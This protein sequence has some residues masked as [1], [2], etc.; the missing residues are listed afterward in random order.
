MG[1]VAAVRL[2]G[3]TKFYGRRLGVQDVSFEVNPGEVV[4]FLGPNGSGKTTVLRML[5]GLLRPTPGRAEVFGSDVS[6]SGPDIRERV[7]YLPGTLSLYQ[8]M[9][10][11]AYL[12]FMAAMRR[13]DCSARATELCERFGVNTGAH[14]GEMSKGN[15]QKVGVVQAFMH[16]PDLLVMDE[17]TSGLDPVVPLPRSWSWWAC[18]SW[19]SCAATSASENPAEA[20]LNLCTVMGVGERK[21]VATKVMA[22][23]IC[24]MV[25]ASA[26]LPLGNRPAHA[27]DSNAVLIAYNPTTISQ[28]VNVSNIA[29]TTQ[30]S[31]TA[32]VAK[33]NWQNDYA[34]LEVRFKNSGGTVLVTKR[35][36]GAGWTTLTS[37]TPVNLTVSLQSTDASWSASI[38]AVEVI[39]GG[40]DGEYWAGNYGTI[41]DYVTL[42]QT[43]SAGTTQLLSNPEFASGSASWSSSAGWQ[44]CSG[45]AGAAACVYSAYSPPTT[46]S[47][48]TTSTTTTSTTTTST[49]TTPD[50][51]GSS[52][53]AWP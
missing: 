20:Q 21:S 35:S 27:S 38:A 1:S 49:T 19:P 7:G 42:E 3:L 37:A 6:Q 39:V 16:D 51:S 48:T 32:N 40:D 4:G 2:I 23:V 46:T 52:V 36:P 15:R 10:A 33:N 13:R 5:V 26:Q 29:D 17:P 28:Q 22:G 12:D 43:T 11:G 45:G 31:V 18:R 24:T 14:I 30:F 47:T 44:A 8:R 25:F 9:T 50:A 53:P 34:Y 41:I